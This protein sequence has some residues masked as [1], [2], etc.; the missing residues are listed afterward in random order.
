MT[1]PIVLGPHIAPHGYRYLETFSLVDGLPRWRW[2]VGDIVVE[3]EHR[4]GSDR[5]GP[6][7]PRTS[8]VKHHR[9]DSPGS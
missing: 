4:V 7:Q 2:R 3:R 1:A 5:G 8:S 9:Q 6:R